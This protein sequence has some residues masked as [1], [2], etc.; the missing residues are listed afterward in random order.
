MNGIAHGVSHGLVLSMIALWANGAAAAAEPIRESQ[1]DSVL[2]KAMQPDAGTDVELEDVPVTGPRERAR[3]RDPDTTIYPTN[4]VFVRLD[5]KI[6]IHMNLVMAQNEIVFRRKSAARLLPEAGSE[7]FKMNERLRLDLQPDRLFVRGT[8]KSLDTAYQL[9]G[10]VDEADGLPAH[11]SFGPDVALV[12]LDYVSIHH[13]SHTTRIYVTNVMH[14]QTRR[15]ERENSFYEFWPA[16]TNQYVM[17]GKSQR[18]CER[19][20]ARREG[21]LLFAGNLPGEFKQAVEELY[22]PIAS[23]MANRLGNEPGNMFIAWWSDSPDDGYRFQLSWNRNSLLLFNGPKWQEGIDPSQQEKLR[24]SFM[25]EQIQRRIRES[26]WPGPFTRSAVRY[27]LLLTDSEENHTTQQRLSQELPTW[28]ASCA[29][30]IL[31]RGAV[32]NEEPDVPSVECGLVL[33]FV[34]DAVARSASAGKQ[35]IFDTWRKLLVASSRRG[36]SGVRPADFLSSSAEARR[37][38]QGLVDGGMDWLKFATALEKLG[39][40]LTVDTSGTLPVFQVQ[41]LGNFG[42]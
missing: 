2:A 10:N 33:Q 17:L 25:L 35:N 13:E 29:G 28:L 15:C 4:N 37:I 23:R 5:D 6:N 1:G 36:R 12:N 38:A 20:V 31:S 42:D 8:S 26:D 30:G 34:Y 40:K 39:V 27:L 24:T 11:I 14:P 32:A 41:S 19:I 7:L 9:A 21:D 16:G 3:K 18:D 22:D